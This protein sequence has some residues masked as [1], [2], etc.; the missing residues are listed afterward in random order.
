MD[1]AQTAETLLS[2]WNEPSAA[3]RATTIAQV[4]AADVVYVDPHVPAPVLGRMGFA[5]FATRFQEMVQGVTVSLEGAPQTHN[6]FGRIRFKIMRGNVP[7]SRGSFFVE[8]DDAQRLKQII[9]FV[10]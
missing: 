1:I 9:G 5:D 4:L 2:I 10:D 6:G 3:K 7:F 8:L